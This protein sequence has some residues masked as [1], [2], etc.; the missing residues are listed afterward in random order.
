MAHGLALIGS[1]SAFRGVP[2]GDTHIVCRT[3]NDYAAAFEHLTDSTYRN[4]LARRGWQA[5]HKWVKD[6]KEDLLQTIEAL[7]RE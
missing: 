3:S 5:L 6:S 7:T 1:P 2:P 4:A